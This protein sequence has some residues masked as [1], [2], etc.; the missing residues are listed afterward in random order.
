MAADGD[1]LIGHAGA[2]LLRKLA[3]QCG[4]TSALGA[5][6]TRAGRFPLID[7]GVALVS[8]AVAIVLGATS[9]SDIALLDHQ[10]PG[11]RLGRSGRRAGRRR[12]RGRAGRG[13]PA[14][15]VVKTCAR[16]Q[17]ILGLDVADLDMEFRRALVVEKGGDRAYVHWETPTARLLP[18]LLQGRTT[19]PVFLADRRAPTS[20]RRAVAPADVDPSTGRG[21]LSYPRAEYLFKQASK[22]HDPHGAGYT[23]HQLRHSGLTHLAA[24][25][26]SAPELQ[27]KS[28]HRH[29]GTL[30]V[31]VQLGRGDR[32][33]HHRRERRASPSATLNVRP[34]DRGHEHAG[35][36]GHE[37]AGRAGV[38]ERHLGQPFIVAGHAPPLSR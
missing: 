27:A 1:G 8:M 35:H 17:E 18:R 2:V 19:G 28:R 4:L 11:R 26:R 14:D 37:H 22:L 36:L 9:M 23:L 6:L 29:L 10:G 5:A 13:L 24:K 15:L 38:L 7:R 34:H 20:G 25:G 12:C 3:D 32:P 31:Y 21:R 33:P 16:A 30:G